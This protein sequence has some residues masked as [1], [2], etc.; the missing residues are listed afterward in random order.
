LG[1]GE[2]G[3]RAIFSGVQ[4]PKVVGGTGRAAKD[5]AGKY[6]TEQCSFGGPVEKSL[7][8]SK[9]GEFL[10]SFRIS[11]FLCSLLLNKSSPPSAVFNNIMRKSKSI[12][13]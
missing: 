1:P 6:K 8:G 3:T 4:V 13:K 9:G 2:G 11:C 5:R 7:T 12:Q 10:S